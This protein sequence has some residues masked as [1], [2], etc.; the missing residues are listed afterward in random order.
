[1]ISTENRNMLQFRR[2]Q[3]KGKKLC[4]WWYGEP[5]DHAYGSCKN[6]TNMIIFVFWFLPYISAIG[7]FYSIF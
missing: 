2:Q 4:N 5:K 7:Y 6:I 1:M 3:M